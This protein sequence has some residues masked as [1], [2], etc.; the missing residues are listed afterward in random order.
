MESV[1]VKSGRHDL[2]IHVFLRDFDRT[3]G[4]AEQGEA[5]DHLDCIIAAGEGAA[6]KLI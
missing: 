6:T 5:P 3:L 2:S 4:H 1:A